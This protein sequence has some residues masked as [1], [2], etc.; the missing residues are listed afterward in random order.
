MARPPAVR[1]RDLG[2]GKQRTDSITRGGDR[3]TRLC[4]P[5]ARE[6]VTNV[7]LRFVLAPR[8]YFGKIPSGPCERP[9]GAVLYPVDGL[10]LPGW[11]QGR[12]SFTYS[13]QASGNPSC[14]RSRTLPS[15]AGRPRLFCAPAAGVW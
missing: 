5:P 2:R 15:P 1:R 14:T 7:C 8:R 13:C 10:V 12:T 4:C 3:T 6:T 9:G 11:N